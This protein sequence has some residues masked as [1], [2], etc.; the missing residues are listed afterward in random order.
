MYRFCAV[1]RDVRRKVIQASYQPSM[2]DAKV[3]VRGLRAERDELVKR[4]NGHMVE[5]KS[6]ETKASVQDV[7][8]EAMRRSV[9]QLRRKMTSLQNKINLC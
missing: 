9:K 1:P 3:T 5:K 7:I 8:I 4:P 6:Q 2:L